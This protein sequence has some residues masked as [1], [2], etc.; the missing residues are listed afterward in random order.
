M[1]HSRNRQFLI[2]VCAAILVMIPRVL[3]ACPSCYGNPDEAMTQGMNFA[4]LSLLGITGGVLAAFAAFFIQL[5]RRARSLQH[6][7]TTLMN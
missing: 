3:S 2:A 7:L 5:R 6:R 4:I 1:G